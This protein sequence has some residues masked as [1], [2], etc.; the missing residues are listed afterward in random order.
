MILIS[1]FVTLILSHREI[2]DE[3]IQLGKGGEVSLDLEDHRNEEFTK[4]KQSVRA[5]TG[6]GVML[7]R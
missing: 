1:L 6:H 2:P 4:P 3:L 7:G 5:F